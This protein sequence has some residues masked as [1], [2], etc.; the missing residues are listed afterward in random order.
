MQRIITEDMKVNFKPDIYGDTHYD[1][2]VRFLHNRCSGKP[3]IG[4]L[5]LQYSRGK[6]VAYP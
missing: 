6:L 4:Q 2:Y 5:V 3:E 1:D